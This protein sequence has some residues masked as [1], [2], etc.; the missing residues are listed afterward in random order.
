MKKTVIKL[1]PLTATVELIPFM[2][3]V[4]HIID[5]MTRLTKGMNE[6]KAVIQTMK[7]NTKGQ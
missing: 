5:A 1:T 2:E 4:D 7:P 3:S 6:L